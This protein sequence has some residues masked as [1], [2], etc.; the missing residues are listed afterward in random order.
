[1]AAAP[2]ERPGV[3]SGADLRERQPLG[4]RAVCLRVAISTMWLPV[5]WTQSASSTID[6]SQRTTPSPL[7]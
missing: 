4:D 6:R 5:T 7:L 2:D 1:M 3:S